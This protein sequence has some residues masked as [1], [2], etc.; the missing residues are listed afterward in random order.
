MMDTNFSL[1]TIK[2]YSNKKF[3]DILDPN[4]RYFRHRLFREHCILVNGN[5]VKD[6]SILGRDLTKTI[7][8]DNSPQAFAYHMDNGIPIES[9]FQ[10][11][12]DEELLQ[13]LP[14]LLSLLNENDVRPMIRSRF[15]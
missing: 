4:R 8:I 12:T 2:L 11:E 10:K 7:I 3:Q 13:L 15:R 1:I 9:W 6:L 14:F 5:Y